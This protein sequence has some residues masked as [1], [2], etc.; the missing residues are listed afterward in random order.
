MRAHVAG[1]AGWLRP[2]LDSQ[3]ARDIV[4]T[5]NSPDVWLLLSQRGWSL[6]DYECWI[7]TGLRSMV[8][9]LDQ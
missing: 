1:A 3:H 8:L 2:G 7:A 4:W 5:L 9:R 6:S